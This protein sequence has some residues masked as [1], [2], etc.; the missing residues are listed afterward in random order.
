MNKAIKSIPETEGVRRASVVNG[1]DGKNQTAVPVTV[2]P[3]NPEVFQVAKRR[4]FSAQ[5]KDSA[6]SRCLYEIG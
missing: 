3:A 1:M 6:G 5:N 4:R 2:S